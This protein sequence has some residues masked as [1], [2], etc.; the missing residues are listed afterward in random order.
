MSPSKCKPHTTFVCVPCLVNFK[1]VAHGEE[2][3]LYKPAVEVEQKAKDKKH[4]LVLDSE[5]D[6]KVQKVR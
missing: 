2:V 1:D 5:K 3:V 4:K 6:V